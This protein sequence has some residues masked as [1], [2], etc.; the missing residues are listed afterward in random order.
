MQGDKILLPAE[1]YVYSE[2]PMT[3]SAVVRVK[4]KR[5]DDLPRGLRIV[6]RSDARSIYAYAAVPTVS[7]PQGMIQVSP[8]SNGADRKTH[9]AACDSL[10][11]GK[12]STFEFLAVNEH[13]ILIV[14][15][16]TV[17]TYRDD[18]PM[19]RG[20]IH[21][22]SGRGAVE[23]RELEVL[24][25]DGLSEDKFPGFVK[26]A[27]GKSRAAS[28]ASSQSLPLAMKPGTGAAPSPG[29]FPPGKWVKPVRKVEDLAEVHR[30]E[31][32]MK[33]EDGWLKPTDVTKGYSF[34]IPELKGAN[35]AVRVVMRNPGAN[36]SGGPVLQLRTTSNDGRYE[37]MPSEGS[38]AISHMKDNPRTPLAKGTRRV[39]V[40]PDRDILIEMAVIGT[41][42]YGRGE[43]GLAVRATNSRL[44]K[45]GIGI[46]SK[47]WLR[48]I[49]VM[50]LDGVPEAEA[51]RL[52]GVDAEGN[53]LRPPDS[54]KF[55]PGRWTKIYT[56]ADQLPPEVRL[57]TSGVTWDDGW[58]RYEKSTRL[59]LPSSLVGNY[60]VRARFQRV[61][62]KNIAYLTLRNQSLTTTDQYKLFN[63]N[64][65]HFTCQATNG[66]ETFTIFQSLVPSPV[67]FDSAYTME[68]GAV[69]NRLVGRLN[70]SLVKLTSDDRYRTGHA[71][72]TG[73]ESTRDIEVI[74]LNGLPEAEA[75]RLLGVDEAGNDL[76][77]QEQQRIAQ[78]RMNEAIVAIPELK[79]LHEQFV[80]LQKER[81]TA[82][83][84]AD[85]AKL[86]AGYLGGL[87]RTL[88]EAKAA[89]RA[90][91]V[92][93]L[94]A[95]KTLIASRQPLPQQDDEKTGE[96]LKKLRGIYRASFAPLEAQREASLKTLTGPLQTRLAALATDFTAK[97]READA[98]VVQEF[99]ASLTAGTPVVASPPAAAESGP[100]NTGP[101]ATGAA[102]ASA[103]PARTLTSADPRAAAE[104][105]FSLGGTVDIE[106]RGTRRTIRN[107]EELP[108]GRID[109]LKVWL[110]KNKVTGNTTGT[111]TTLEPLAGLKKLTHLETK[112]YEVQD[113]DTDVL[114]TFPALANCQI[115]DARKFT[116]QRLGLLRGLDNLD[117][118]HLGGSGITGAGLEAVATLKRVTRMDLSNTPLT[119]ADLAA[120]AE[121]KSLRA[122]WIRSTKFTAAGLAHLKKLDALTEVGW[123]FQTGTTVEDATLISQIFP[124]LGTL[125]METAR[126]LSG[127]E[128]TGA[129]AHF[130]NLGKVILSNGPTVNDEQ[131]RALA[132]VQ[133]LTNIHFASS[134]AITDSTFE[135]LASHKNLKSLRVDGAAGF[136]RTGLL[137]LVRLKS[138]A[139]LE[140]RDNK[141]LDEAAF[142]EF[143]KQRSDVTVVK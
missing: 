23:F 139:R 38:L 106:D 117:M 141:Q 102:P 96:T 90:D 138:L 136:T 31:G 69:G 9:Q 130:P 68:F 5:T 99:M 93:A 49:E 133:T 108:K 43:G 45:G 81:V 88:S 84:E 21:L 33:W 32:L 63:S 65:T 37:M 46:H 70:D 127:S 104:W 131:G 39:I 85:L 8:T 128:I 30:K 27:L 60:G 6:Q 121:M 25:L 89:A 57:P 80:A 123:R 3:K 135:A 7:T 142:A 35:M 118:L 72:F 36:P 66:S 48:D 119:D 13:Y 78:A 58:V 79:Q 112:A 47:S 113:A 110:D 109:I 29:S 11:P 73:S 28:P 107:L 17:V 10:A 105:V 100:A 140:L 62:G 98:K 87:E 24:A 120:L 101:T 55:V 14:D 97:G 54:E 111:F 16:K 42:L 50:N 53:D 94:E 67:S 137:A 83:F 22:F 74:N 122:L 59:Y 41:Q 95:E 75:L 82:P 86:N 2:L 64:G 34:S 116:G 129:L 132:E 4:V 143:K 103:G 51:L 114:A 61:N 125:T 115:N 134:P 52:I 124:R 56:Q 126:D 71:Y 1:S 91:D 15:G 40:T 19:Q 92:A 18:R 26:D 44:A 20:A 12:E 76:R 77:P